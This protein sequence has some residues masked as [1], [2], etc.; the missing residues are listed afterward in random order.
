ME[1][2]DPLDMQVDLAE[3]LGLLKRDDTGEQYRL[4][5][6]FFWSKSSLGDALWSF[7]MDLLEHGVLVHAD[8]PGEYAGGDLAWNPDFDLKK[9]L[10]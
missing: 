2:K 1:F 3:R 5:K 10:L 8:A 6:A 7:T 9:C 4:H